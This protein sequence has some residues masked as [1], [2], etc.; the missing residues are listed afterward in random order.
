ME[1]V[2]GTRELFAA[3][4]T[5]TGFRPDL[6]AFGGS[7]GEVLTDGHPLVSGRAT[8]LPGLYFCGF[9][10]SS[11]GML[12]EIG[13]EASQIAREIHRNTKHHSRP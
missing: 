6:G 8:S 10:V 2:D 3:L 11:T 9:H 12:R 13:I 7:L 5:A 4:V 1:F